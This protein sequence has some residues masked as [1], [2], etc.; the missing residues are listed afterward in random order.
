MKFVALDSRG[1]NYLVVAS[2]IAW[3]RAAENGQTTVQIDTNGDG[4]PDVTFTVNGG[5]P[6]D[7]CKFGYAFGTGSFVIPSGPCAGTVTGLDGT[8]TP[9]PGTFLFDGAGQV[10]Q[11]FFVPPGA[12]GAV[13]VQAINLADCCT[14]NVILIP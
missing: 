4:T 8:A 14:S 6:G 9:V 7:P 11:T 3:L 13:Y 10:N 2:N 12:C 5:A 1:G